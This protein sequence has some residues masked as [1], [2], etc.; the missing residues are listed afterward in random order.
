M[1]IDF[2]TSNWYYFIIVLALFVGGF[3]VPV[4]RQLA[5]VGFRSL[6]SEAVIKRMVVVMLE[7]LVK[8]TKNKLDDVWLAQVKKKME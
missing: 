2:I 8:S 5:M 1:I 4:I 7:K 6:L 3:Y